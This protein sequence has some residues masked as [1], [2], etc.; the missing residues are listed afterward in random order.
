MTYTIRTAKPSDVPAFAQIEINAGELFKTVGLDSLAGDHSSPEFVMS[1]VKTGGAFA[2]VQDE[3]SI[4]GFAL[5]FALDNAIHLQEMSVDPMHGRQG[6]GGRLL[7]AVAAWAS[8]HDFTHVTL[9][10]FEDVAWNAPFY[11]RHGYE[12]VERPNWT[13][14]LHILHEHEVHA[15][16]PVARRCFMSKSIE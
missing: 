15:G 3:G 12:I 13:P 14:G 10:T 11:K 8:K 9:S 2:A 7:Q 5:A 1:F 4:V 6:L 16:L